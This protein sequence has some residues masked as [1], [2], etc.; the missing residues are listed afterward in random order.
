MS[1]APP[2]DDFVDRVMDEV[3]RHER[4]LPLVVAALAISALVLAVPAVVVLLARPAFDAA[5][6][7]ALAGAAEATS[8]VADN[9]LFW[10][11][12]ALTAVWLAWLAS[13]AL[14]GRP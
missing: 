11:G 14:R 7:L 4:R 10:A 2:P 9:P 6:S 1:P 3:A 13:R 12:A 8:A 5:L